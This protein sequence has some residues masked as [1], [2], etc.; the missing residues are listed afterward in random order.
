VTE[1]L[2]ARVSSTGL[3]DIRHLTT[4]AKYRSFLPFALIAF[5]L[6]LLLFALRVNKY[7]LEFYPTRWIL[8]PIFLCIILS[9][10][11]RTDEKLIVRLWQLIGTLSAIY[12][13]I[14]YPLFAPM[15]SNSYAIGLYGLVLI[16]WVISVLWGMFSFYVPSFAALPPAFLVWCN[17]AARPITGLPVTI[18]LDIMPL[19]EVS[20]C[21]GLGLLI[22]RSTLQATRFLSTRYQLSDRIIGRLTSPSFVS[23]LLLIAISI[24]LANYY[25]S[26]IAKI[27]LDGP[28]LAW[29]TKNNPANRFLVGLDNDQI[30]FAG[31]PLLVRLA[32]NLVDAVHVYSNFLIL[33]IQGLAITAFFLPKRALVALLLAFDVMHFAIIILAGANF[34]PWI[35]LN[36]IIALIVAAP[37]YEPQP[38]FIRLVA[39]LFIFVAPRFV[40]VAEL[41]WYDTG[42][43]NKLFFEAVD[44]KGMRYSVP[45][46]FFTFYSYSFGHMDYGAINPL[47]SFDVDSSG[48]GYQYDILQAAVTCDARHL[49]KAA[50]DSWSYQEQ[51]DAFIRNYHHR[52]TRI[53]SAMG[54]FP[55]DLYPHHFYVPLGQSAQFRHLNKENIVAYIYRQET[56]CLSF[57]DGRLKRRVVAAFERRIDLDPE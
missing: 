25:W 38:I 4:L 12:S 44:R 37:N 48:S 2:A 55:Y 6:L 31:Y 53:E 5:Q 46:N 57:S 39:T 1:T 51:M 14:H 29:L 32:Y 50:A 26:F 35:I 36:L 20:I 13:L 3:Y 10:R 47:R 27:S 23:L 16:F 9:P 41:G 18:D 8:L 15:A 21:I 40:Q 19:N 54:A 33:L 42:V 30:L 28:V 45:T 49:Y 17:F 7:L 52:V 43:N 24:H 11:I 34:W 56:V 22:S